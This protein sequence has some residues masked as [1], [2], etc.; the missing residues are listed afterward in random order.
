MTTHSWT[1]SDKL[2]VGVVLGTDGANWWDVRVRAFMGVGR[3]AM[4]GLTAVQQ[5]KQ[6]A[7]SPRHPNV[8]VLDIV[9]HNI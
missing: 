9:N 3:W 5:W 2:I 1:L 6:V 7:I 4:M 8:G